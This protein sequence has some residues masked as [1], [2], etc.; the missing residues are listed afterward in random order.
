MEPK[1]LQSY[2]IFDGDRHLCTI[3]EEVK[4]VQEA[5]N[6]ERE[7]ILSLLNQAEKSAE[8]RVVH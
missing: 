4:S 8:N 6:Y 1:L 3:E 2:D 7:A 5:F